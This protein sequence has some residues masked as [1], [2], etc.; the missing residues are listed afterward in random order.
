MIAIDWLERNA[1]GFR[2]LSNDER[3]VITNFL[4]LWSLFETKVLDQHGN[5]DTIVK[6]AKQWT[7]KGL[8][9]QESFEP[10]VSYFR[11]RYYV[12]GKYT[13]H[14]EHLHLRENDLPDLVNK[15]L[16]NYDAD[17]DELAG[18]VLIIIYRFRNNL[19]HGMKWS[20][21][22]RGQ[23]E[24]FSHANVALMNAIELQG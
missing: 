17:A 8:L 23:L 13:Y 12:N 14:F 1:P 7:R 3:N 22:L 6:A 18:A 24:N 2:E 16:Q 20:Y 11:N 19:F 5:A 15:V 10:Q 9:T 21:E 4:F